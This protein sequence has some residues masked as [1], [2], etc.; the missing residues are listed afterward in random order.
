MI[1]QRAADPGA[2]IDRLTGH[3]PLADEE[4]IS[5]PEV[6]EACIQSEVEAFRHGL[7]GIAWDTH[8]LTRPWG[9]RLEDIRVPVFLWHGS[10]DDSTPI[11]MGKYVASK[12]P[13]CR[14]IICDGEAHLLLFPHWEEILTQL[15]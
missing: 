10:A 5:R 2:D 6:R 9:F 12:I 7:R 14:A 15:I 1:H 13:N 3:R 11:S 4:Q 8:L